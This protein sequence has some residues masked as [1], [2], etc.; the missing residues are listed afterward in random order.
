[1]EEMADLKPEVDNAVSDQNELKGP[2][3]SAAGVRNQEIS[4]SAVEVAINETETDKDLLP[5]AR[6]SD[7]EAVMSDTIAVTSDTA[8]T[9]AVTSDTMAVTSST[10]AVASDTMAVTSDTAAENCDNI[11]QSAAGMDD[12]D[13][14]NGIEPVAVV[15]QPGEEGEAS[16]WWLSVEEMSHHVGM[17]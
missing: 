5:T 9:K 11:E 8:D 12:I 17:T 2:E 3:S 13:L 15:D 6:E 14:Q 4:T 10:M 16:C 7:T 1:M